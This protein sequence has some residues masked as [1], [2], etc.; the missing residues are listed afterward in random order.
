LDIKGPCGVPA[1]NEVD[2]EPGIGLDSDGVGA[3]HDGISCGP[4]L[5]AVNGNLEPGSLCARGVHFGAHF[6]VARLVRWTE[7]V[8][9]MFATDKE[10]LA[11]DM[12]GDVLVGNAY[13]TGY[14]GLLERDERNSGTVLRIGFRGE[15]VWTVIATEHVVLGVL[16]RDVYRWNVVW[17]RLGGYAAIPVIPDITAREDDQV[18]GYIAAV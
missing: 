4:S 11:M 8:V 14:P 12:I 15:F 1:V 2:I 3:N 18:N 5:V 7:P 10:E 17:V 16:P 13:D 6:D 9:A